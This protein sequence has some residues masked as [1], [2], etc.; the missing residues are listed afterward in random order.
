MAHKIYSYIIPMQ[1]IVK[2]LSFSM[3]KNQVLKIYGI[4]VRFVVLMDL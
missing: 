1:T 4:Q 3:Q 2:I